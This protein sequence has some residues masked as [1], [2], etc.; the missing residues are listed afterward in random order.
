MGSGGPVVHAQASRYTPLLS[1]VIS[2][3]G[4]PPHFSSL[5]VRLA[6]R[7][8]TRING[9]GYVQ[10]ETSLSLELKEVLRDTP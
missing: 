6:S 5:L 10:G 7:Y 8:A 4:L 9:P 3:R 1:S 2:L